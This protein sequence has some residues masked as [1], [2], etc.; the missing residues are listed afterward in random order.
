MRPLIRRQSRIQTRNRLSHQTSEQLGT[1]YQKT[2][3]ENGIRVVSEQIPYVRS[4][5]IGLWIEVG[6][7]DEDATSNG[8]SHF[9]EHMVFKGT[10]QRSMAEISRSIESVGGYL[11]AF[12]SKEHT[13][14]YARM[15]DQHTDL[16]MDVVSDLVLNASFPEK[17]I[18]KEKNV[19]IEELRNAEDDPDD[20]IHDYLEKALYGDH[21][22]GFPVI[23]TETNLRSFRRQDLL[24]FRRTHYA[25]HRMV[26]AAAGNIAHEDLLRLADRYLK[27]VRSNGKS[28]GIRRGRPTHRKAVRQEYPRPIQQA[29]VCMGMRAYDIKSKERYPLLVLNTLFG[30]GMSSRLFQNIRERYG[31]AYNVYSFVNFLSDTGSFGVYV[32]TDKKHVDAS[33]ELVEKEIQRLVSRPVSK[34]ELLRT[35]AQLKGN[36]MLSLENIPNR[37]I[38]L[39]TSEIYFHELTSLDDILRKIEDVSQEDLLRVSND[40]FCKSD[41]AVVILRPKGDDQVMP[42]ASAADP[43][44]AG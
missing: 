20:I 44:D 21:P 22:M 35:K 6:S 41:R 18:D 32:G 42:V 11:N 23:G 9:V 31:F 2:T 17:E 7:R 13:C 19:V 37:M 5:S 30:E 40:M 4:V 16:A 29:H 36:M 27:P 26:L 14:F 10:K 12:T 38:R 25:P 33:M 24:N 15:L 43:S 28:S 1:L 39:G 34:A 8:L 3:L